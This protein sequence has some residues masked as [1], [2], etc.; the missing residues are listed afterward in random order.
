MTTTTDHSDGIIKKISPQGLIDYAWFK[1]MVTNQ[2]LKQKLA[3]LSFVVCDIDATLT[4]GGIYFD[5]HGERGRTFFVPDGYGIVQAQK[6]GL[7]FSFISGKDHPS[8]Q[9]RGIQL[10][11]ANDFLIGGQ[12]NKTESIVMLQK[13]LGISQHN[14]LIIGDDFLDLMV[15][16]CGAAALFACPADA[17]F[18]IQAASDIVLPRD[19]GRGALRVL[20]D[21]ILFCQGKHFAQKA[22]EKIIF[23]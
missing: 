19:G 11:I 3:A 9:E 14:T 6:T 23:T 15:K 17:V 13:K 18:Y 22:L 4:D 12:Q 1:A 8:L 16:E 7:V 5:E 10:G 21:L 20:I 2:S